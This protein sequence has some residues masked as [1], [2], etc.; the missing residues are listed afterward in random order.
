[1]EVRPKKIAV[2]DNS[3]LC[4]KLISSA[5]SALPWTDVSSF[6][7]G[8]K[9]W[10]AISEGDDADIIIADI[11]KPDK[12]GLTL[13][14]KI[15]AK[16]PDKPCI[17]MSA[18]PRNKKDASDLCADCFLAKPFSMMDLFQAVERLA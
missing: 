13:L 6:E 14:R 17:I 2:V 5:L 15:K 7:D 1:M 18:T 4:R 3:S 12:D 10:D 8:E 11:N 9:A 16:D